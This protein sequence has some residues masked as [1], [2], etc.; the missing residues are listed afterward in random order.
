M[1]EGLLLD[2]KKR[3]EIALEKTDEQ[4]AVAY[5]TFD[6]AVNSANLVRL[7][8]DT[9]LKFSEILG[10]QLPELISFENRELEEKFFEISD[11]LLGG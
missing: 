4:I 2:Q 9:Q 5:S 6:T 7:I 1:Y 11:M 8:D 3:L 10:A